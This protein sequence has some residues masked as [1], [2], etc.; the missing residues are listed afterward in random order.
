MSV[1]NICT[2][3][4]IDCQI[5]F[6]TSSPA[7]TCSGKVVLLPVKDSDQKIQWKIWVLS[8]ILKD[9]NVHKEDESLLPS[10]G[11]QLGGPQD[12]EVDV[13]IIGGGNA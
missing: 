12:I 8:T 6:E 13:F 5:V 4:F 10:P 3:Q 7:A 1:A 9:L 11:R 2:Q